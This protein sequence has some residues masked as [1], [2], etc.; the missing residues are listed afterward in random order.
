MGMVVMEISAVGWACH[1]RVALHW[2]TGTDGWYA[3]E[4]V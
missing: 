1:H 4:G 3:W 2:P